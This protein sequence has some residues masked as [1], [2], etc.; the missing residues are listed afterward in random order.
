MS[1]NYTPLQSTA[2]RLLEQFG[3]SCTHTQTT[4]DGASTAT[5][6]VALE[7]AITEG[8]R[9]RSAIA[10]TPLPAHK[11]LVS[12]AVTPV[13]GARLVVGSSTTVIMQFDP[14]R[15][16]GTVLAWYVYGQAG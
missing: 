3:Q 14:I 10:G 1:Y 7:L 12:A 2:T 8:E 16:A 4:R 13:K 11:F 6:G 5:T 9:N 15:P